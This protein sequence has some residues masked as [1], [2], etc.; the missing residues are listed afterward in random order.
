MGV[1]MLAPRAPADAASDTI[2]AVTAFMR[3]GS[4]EATRPNGDD[5]AAPKRA[6]PAGTRIYL[7]ALLT[8]PQEEV[9]AQAAG[10]RAAGLEPVPHLAVRNFASADALRRFLDRLAGEAGVRRLLVIAGDRAEPAGPFRGALEAIDSGLITRSG[11]TEIGISGYPDGHPRIADHE[12]ERVLAAKLE[13][14]EQTGLKVN[15]LTQFCLDAGPIIAWVRRLRAHGIDH[16]VRIGLAG[17]TSLTTL[18]RYAR[19]C[20]VRASTQGLARNAGLI[21]HLLG[22]AAPDSAIRALI[23]ANRD[24]ELGDIAPHL[25]SFGGIGATARWAAGAAAGRIKPDRDGF[26]VEG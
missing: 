26:A 3:A 21:K 12:L 11:I 16:P 23:E 22:A 7:S 19:R 2:A 10:L 25:F 15:I 1:A 9:V 6:V 18:M 17:P 5:I 24:G 20:G 8:R 14:A 4:L 13:A